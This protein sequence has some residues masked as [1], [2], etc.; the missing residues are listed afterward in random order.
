MTEPEDQRTSETTARGWII[1]PGYH[2]QPNAD[3]RGN[4]LIEALPPILTTAEGVRL[5]QRA[6]TYDPGMRLLDDHYRWHAIDQVNT[7]FLALP[8]VM[9]IEAK[10][11]VMIRSGY[12]PRNPLRR[13]F[14]RRI[15]LA[16]EQ[17][18]RPVSYLAPNAQS[19][20]GLVVLGDPGVGKSS[21]MEAVLGTYPQ[22]IEH[23]E[24][25]DPH[26]ESAPTKR[27]SAL[28]LVYLLVRCPADGS[29]KALLLAIL[30]AMDNTLETDYFT[31]FG[32]RGEASQGAMT[33]HVARLAAHHHLGV[34]VIDEIQAMRQATEDSREQL[35][36]FLVRLIDDLKLPVV[37]V[38]GASARPVLE[39]QIRMARRGEGEGTVYW[40]RMPN[41]AFWKSFVTTLWRYQ[42]LTTPTPLTD[43]LI[44]TLHTE[45]LGIPD[46]AVKLFRFAQRRAINVAPSRDRERLTPAI[47]H[48]VAMDS[49]RLSRKRLQALRTTDPQELLA[50]RAKED[51]FFINI[52]EIDKIPSTGDR[53]QSAATMPDGANPSVAAGPAIALAIP[54][55][56][57]VADEGKSATTAGTVAAVSPDG[58]GL[59]TP[60]PPAPRGHPIAATAGKGRYATVQE[61]GLTRSAAEFEPTEDRP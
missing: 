39:A 61:A 53:D 9:E 55:A 22:V 21:T 26:D 42:Y 44:E 33:P 52:K 54:D 50:L 58:R 13:G 27:F 37:I 2:E 49:I 20:N 8:N 40:R 19:S 18:A 57:A 14:S 11:S 23:N 28:Q 12:V 29:P 60:T 6:P 24:Y 59:A 32:R 51:D 35:L 1:H 16:V 41:D 56:G 47:V 7:L 5:L 38:G 25:V 31:R 3:Y 10:V 36:N 17:F 46:Y 34:L 4:P 48:S 30:Q 43:K 45:S 15:D